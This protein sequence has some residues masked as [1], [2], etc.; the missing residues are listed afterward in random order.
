L[1]VLLGEKS[2]NGKRA[3][4]RSILGKK[5]FVRPRHFL[6]AFEQVDHGRMQ[7]WLFVV[8]WYDNRYV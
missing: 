5:D 1:V 6:Q 7:N 8:D 4:T 2:R 3:V